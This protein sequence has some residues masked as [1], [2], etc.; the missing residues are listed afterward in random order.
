SKFIVMHLGWAL[1]FIFCFI[2]WTFVASL[3]FRSTGNCTFIK[4]V[5]MK[6]VCKGYVSKD[7]FALYKDRRAPQNSHFSIWEGSDDEGQIVLA[8]F[9]ASPLAEH[10]SLKIVP[11]PSYP[12]R[13]SFIVESQNQT[14]EL[15]FVPS[16]IHCFDFSLRYPMELRR[17]CLG[18][19]RETSGDEVAKQPIL[20]YGSF[21]IQKITGDTSSRTI[22][23]KRVLIMLA[24]FT[25]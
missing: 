4:D 10:A 25:I 13:H 2:P 8:S 21:D 15:Q 3:R 11:N 12:D 14:L 9:H 22:E 18:Q 23:L 17:Q 7:M 1:V 16:T 19:S 20:H 6:F 24:T 5:A